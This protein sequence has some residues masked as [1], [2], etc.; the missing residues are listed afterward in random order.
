MKVD[1]IAVNA[2]VRRLRESAKS[3][4][5][6][7]FFEIKNMLNEAANMVE[8]LFKECYKKE[9]CGW[10]PCKGRLPDRDGF[11]LATMD[12]EI[13]GEDKP[14]SGLAEFKNGK[15]DDDEVDYQCV[16]AWKPLPE[17]YHEH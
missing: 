14:F 7:G 9:G 2:Q 15:W 13:I 10:I 5:I 4:E 17:P 6:F 8:V 16:L 3:C 12:G 1:K 11:Y